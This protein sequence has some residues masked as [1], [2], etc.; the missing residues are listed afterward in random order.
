MARGV[1]RY[2]IILSTLFL[3]TI[4][5]PR[6]SPGTGQ[7]LR[8]VWVFFTDK[9][10]GIHLSGA[11]S[12]LSKGTAASAAYEEALRFLT[13]RA[14]KRRA[15]VLPADALV[16]EADLAVSPTYL[17]QIR[18]VAGAPVNLSRW[19]NAASYLLTPDQ[20]SRLRSVPF[21]SGVSPVATGG[22][23]PLPSEQ[24][25]WVPFAQAKAGTLDYGAS[26]NQA[27]FIDVPALHDL[28][29]TGKGVLV[30]MLDT[31]FRWR[32][33]EA[34]NTR[35]VIA[36]KDFIQH[37]DT[38]ANQDGDSP[39]QDYHGTTTMSVLGGYKPGTL[40]GPAFDADFILAKT[41]FVPVTDSSWEEDNWAAGIEWEEANGVDV[42]SSSVGYNVFVD[43]PDYT[44]GN[45]D[46]NGRTTVSARA[47]VRAA[48][49]GVVVSQAMGNEGNG[50]GFTGTLITPADADSILSV[51]AVTFS[52]T[53]AR[54]SSTGPTNDGRFKPD[55]VAP[56]VGI[57]IAEP[58]NSY[59]GLGQGTSYSTPL[60]TASAALVLSARPELTPIQVR[61]A[62]RNTADTIWAWRQPFFPNNFTGWGLV[63]AFR[64]AESFG[65]IFSHEPSLDT[66]AL[67]SR[68]SIS[69]ASRFGIGPR[70]L[71]LHFR[72][73]PSSYLDL[74]MSREQLLGPTAARYFG[75][76]PAPAADTVIQYYITAVDSAGNVYQNPPEGS[77]AP[78]EFRFVRG[79]KSSNLG[80]VLE[81]NFPN[82]VISA[83]TIRFF[84]PI[85]LQVSLRI[86]NTI[87]QLVRTLVDGERDAGTNEITWDGTGSE[88]TRVASGVYFYRFSSGAAAVTG[89]LV[90]L[91]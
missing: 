80:A 30:G 17:E 36:E 57:F 14:L 64:A 8:K 66:S 88:G 91:R 72:V 19:A 63:D 37:D 81:P 62:I 38:T 22:I 23:R 40:I 55:V 5:Y 89:K 43:R 26:L 83:T 90:L 56:G 65:P 28:G 47:A 6:S 13:S 16:E 85:R 49:L 77:A 71:V 79:S 9:G 4:A 39:D 33:H 31:G 86:Y 34:L 18:P 73:P 50:D 67:E 74:T 51:G 44:W 69:A 32:I 25:P 7:S 11:S 87:G 61:D 58:P 20:V 1:F 59:S 60:A 45:G 15:K 53:L 27:K 76:I 75:V 52:R 3:A 41:E 10:P 2:P 68:V 24:V 48:R 54:F 29:I 78:W 42:V 21:V 35:H 46:F 70:G 84:L 12:A 82:P